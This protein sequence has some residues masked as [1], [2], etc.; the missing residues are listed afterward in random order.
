MMVSITSQTDGATSTA[1]CIAW[2][3]SLS[4]N[5]LELTSCNAGLEGAEGDEEAEDVV[6]EARRDD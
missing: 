3:A 1:S 6:E 4:N 5:V 2:I